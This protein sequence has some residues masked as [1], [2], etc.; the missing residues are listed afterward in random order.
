MALVILPQEDGS[1]RHRLKALSNRWVV[2]DGR[3]D[4]EQTRDAL[5]RPDGGARMF[6]SATDWDRIFRK[7]GHDA[8]TQG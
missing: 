3:D 1:R 5:A 7:G 2:A 4:D 8:G 6:L